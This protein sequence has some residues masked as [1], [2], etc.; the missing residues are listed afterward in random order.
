M[1]EK[2]S[3]VK[4]MLGHQLEFFL[5]DLKNKSCLTFGIHMTNQKIHYNKHLYRQKK[6]KYFIFAVSTYIINVS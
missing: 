6:K 5:I 2:V 4:W 1:Y 3:N